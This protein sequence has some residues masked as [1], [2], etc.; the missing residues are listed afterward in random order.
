[1]T[2]TGF[3]GSYAFL[4]NFFWPVVVTYQG[5]RYYS[6][7]HAY[8]A[9][10]FLSPL[11]RKEFQGTETKPWWAK[12]RAKQLNSHKRPDWQQVNLAIMKDL[13]SQKFSHPGLHA[14]LLAT[15]DAELVE[16]NWWGDTFWGV[17]KGQGENHL[18]RLL[19][20][21]RSELRQMPLG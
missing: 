11:F 13:L 3:R 16:G 4:S 18:G 14:L 6:T 21:V 10:K 19:M 7:E 12:K 9:A 8:Q 20:E 17:C 5:D 15:G 1:M 2:I